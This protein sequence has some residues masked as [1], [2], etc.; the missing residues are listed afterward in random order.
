METLLAG[1]DRFSGRSGQGPAQVVDTV[2]IAV[3]PVL[4]GSGIPLVPPGPQAK[5]KLADHKVLPGSGIVVLAYAVKGSKAPP[6]RIKHIK[7]PKKKET[8]R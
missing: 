2:E 1:C 3:M 5:L 4:L 6:P 7:P 8:A